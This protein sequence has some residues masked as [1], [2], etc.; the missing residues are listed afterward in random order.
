MRALEV[1]T[2]LFGLLSFELFGQLAR[3]FDPADA[4]F[5]HAVDELADRL[6]L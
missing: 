2:A 6:G 4:L 5:A 3:T 1:R